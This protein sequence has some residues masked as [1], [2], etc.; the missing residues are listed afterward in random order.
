MYVC[1]KD[2]KLATVD[3]IATSYGISRNHLM[4]VV[5]R[6]GQ[7]GYLANLRG[8]GGGMRLA[9]KPEEISLGRLVRQTEDD[10]KIVEC[11]QSSGEGCRIESACVLRKALGEALNAFLS[12][13]DGYTLA[14][15]LAP[16]LRLAR[17]LSLSPPKTTPRRRAS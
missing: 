5:F 9:M 7:L 3:E 10:M 12:V 13:L 15:L 2:G 17:L 8:K 11:F 1:T 14:D 6:L 4:K 16:R